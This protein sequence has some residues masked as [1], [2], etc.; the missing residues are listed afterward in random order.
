MVTT[1]KRRKVKNERL[2]KILAIPVF[3][4]LSYGAIRL[5]IAAGNLAFNMDSKIVKDV[6]TENLKATLNKSLP[7]IDTVYNS[8]NINISLSGQ[9]AGLIAEIF[10]FDINSPLTIL[11]AQSSHFFSY[12]KNEYPAILE[13]RI[14][15]KEN[16]SD[17]K[18]ADRDP[19]KHD[20]SEE[21]NGDGGSGGKPDGNMENGEGKDHEQNTGFKVDASSIYFEETDEEKDFSEQNTVSSGK[22]LLQN[23]SKFK[24]TNED[25]EKMLK[26]PLNIKFDRKGPKILIYHTHTSES[27]LRNLDQLG[28]K[29]VAS[30]SR[31]PK[32]NMIRVG[33]ELANLLEKKYGIDVIHNG[34]VHDYPSHNSA[35]S[36]SLR[37]LD[38]Y[39]KSYP[40]IKITLDIHRDAVSK[41]KPKLRV[42]TE[43]DGKKTAKIMFV[44][45]TNGTGLQHPNWR[46]NLKL[47]IK[48]QENLNSQ[49]PDL[50]RPIYI[51][52]NRYNQH[53]A[54]GGALIIEV[55]ADGNTLDEALESI[56]YL[57]KAINDVINGK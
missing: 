34:T 22:I 33:N 5:G 23:M 6:D 20:P 45:G 11:N 44:V 41:D 21:Y 54:S 35:Y 28:K 48:L 31:D 47:A 25:I 30:S 16:D 1:R 29:D 38:K 4:I 8:G 24:I 55:G 27:Y 12:Y 13:G 43:I 10:G 42:V 52:N 14:S 2:A 3:I 50:T 56:K 17:N 37:T 46:E 51:S 32:Y 57:A 19:D 39:L 7:I 18:T 49:H 26:E 40:S 15:D 9:I 36:N 53:L